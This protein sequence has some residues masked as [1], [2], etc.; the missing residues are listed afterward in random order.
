M[1]GQQKMVLEL[2][3]ENKELQLEQIEKKSGIFPMKLALILNEFLSMG[4][5]K[6]RTGGTR[7]RWYVPTDNGR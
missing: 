1:T 2:L 6:I 5:I 4:I 7:Q 3:V